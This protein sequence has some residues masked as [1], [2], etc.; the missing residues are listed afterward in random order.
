MTSISAPLSDAW[1]S[2]PA[3][4]AS[5]QTVTATVP[6]SRPAPT[7]APASNGQVTVDLPEISPG[8]LH[9]SVDEETG[10]VVGKIFD[11]KSGELLWQVPSDDIL[12]LAAAT[13]KM[14]GP[15][16]STEA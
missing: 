3:L 7:P 2:P 10:R 5:K 12:R 9:L 14:L 13:E 1:A 11:R 4:T 6:A 8:K 16:Y 15:L